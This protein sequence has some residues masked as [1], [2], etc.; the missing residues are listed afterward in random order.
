[1]AAFTVAGPAAAVTTDSLAPAAMTT[2]A[3]QS[4]DPSCY[5]FE[6]DVCLT[7]YLIHSSCQEPGGED[8]RMQTIAICAMSAGHASL[9]DN[10]VSYLYSWL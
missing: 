5:A 8:G 3:A 1:M 6:Y 9:E 2:A 4:T 10:K 7:L